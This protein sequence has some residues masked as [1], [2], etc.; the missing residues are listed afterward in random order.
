MNICFHDVNIFISFV[1][2]A[3]GYSYI[4]FVLCALGK[5]DIHA[6]YCIFFSYYK[7]VNSM[8]G[9][10]SIY[11]QHP[12]YE[13]TTYNQRYTAQSYGPLCFIKQQRQL[14]FSLPGKQS[15]WRGPSFWLCQSGKNIPFLYDKNYL[16]FC[17]RNYHN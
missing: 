4:S 1:L 11:S 13:S 7:E 15:D 3:P 8:S 14:L 5:I 16:V 2:C 9:G 6:A 10:K 12:W 17:N